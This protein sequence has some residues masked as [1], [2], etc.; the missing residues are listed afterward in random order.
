MHN[1]Y[2]NFVKEFFVDTISFLPSLW[3]CTKCV[4][5]GGVDWLIVSWIKV[6]REK[7][8]LQAA[9][10][11]L[12]LHLFFLEKSSLSVRQESRIDRVSLSFSSDFI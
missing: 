4:W 12:N 1:V 9:T 6:I 11:I 5:G 10:R 2:K 3:H 7:G 8:K